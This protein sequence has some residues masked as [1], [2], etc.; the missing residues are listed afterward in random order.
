M[1]LL[2]SKILAILSCF[3]ESF[4]Y[5]FTLDVLSLLTADPLFS[6]VAAVG[7]VVVGHLQARHKLCASGCLIRE[8][9]RTGEE[10]GV[11]RCTNGNRA[12]QPI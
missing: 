11:H 3:N 2:E 6:R 1:R 7:V 9:S 5:Y 10:D 4:S 8:R 12:P